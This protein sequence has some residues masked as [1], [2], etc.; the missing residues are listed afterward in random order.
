M[1]ISI[2]VVF[3]FISFRIAPFMFIGFGLN[4]ITEN[5]I[6]NGIGFIFIFIGFVHMMFKLNQ[7]LNS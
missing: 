1:L 6:V 7:L 5:P 4:Y 3:G 2:Y